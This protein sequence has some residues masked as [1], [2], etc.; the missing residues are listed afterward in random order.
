[1][2]RLKLKTI[3][4]GAVVGIIIIFTSVP[5]FLKTSHRDK[6]SVMQDDKDITAIT[7]ETVRRG[8]IRKWVFA[9]GT[10]HAVQRA[11]MRFEHAG[12]VVFIGQ[13]QKGEPLREGMRVQG[14]Q[15]EGAPGQLLA[16]VDQRH[17][18]EA[19]H[20]AIA[21]REQTVNETEAA[22]AYV[23]Q[24]EKQLELSRSNHKRY[25]NL[26]QKSVVS[27]S[28]M[29]KYR[30][31]LHSTTAGLREA[32]ARLLAARAR[33]DQAN[34]LVM[35]TKIDIERASIRAPFDG[36]IAF[37]N[38][39]KGDFFSP[40]SLLTDKTEDMMRTFPIVII[41]PS[42]IEVSVDVPAFEGMGIREGQTALLRPIYGGLSENDSDTVPC[43]DARVH[44]VSAAVFPDRRSYRVTV[45]AF[46]QTNRLTEG[47][48]VYVKICVKERLEATV[49]SPQ[50]LVLENRDAFV[51]K[52]NPNDSTVQ[53]R[54]VKLG[55]QESNRVEILEGL[56]PGAFIAAKGRQRLVDG[57]KVRRVENKTAE[58]PNDG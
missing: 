35:Q 44:A 55:V 57:M 54:L 3:L 2:Q 30:E 12:K 43:I 5:I 7:V 42:L 18:R 21:E 10:A 34:A 13:N 52:W 36:V 48:L 33:V 56:D 41:D 9:E 22:K 45:R 8:D 28:V 32:Q 20:S 6:P 17:L 37:L 11:F 46:G 47:S 25:Q 58:R 15:S 24:A 49:V 51:F 1:M 31:E 26:L 29:E 38:I 27:R 50:S 40:E 23:R 14:P 19:L 4:W 39:K 53:R 16:Q